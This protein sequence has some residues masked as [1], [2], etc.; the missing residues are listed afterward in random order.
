MIRVNT[1]EAK[2]RLSALLAKVERDHE[3]VIIC[4]DGKPVARLEAI[5]V[6]AIDPLRMNP[7]LG[8]VV[9]HENPCA[10]LDEQ[11]WPKEAP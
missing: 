2:M 4:R 7:R 8:P 11:D 10:G 5:E 3:A 9:F 1:H 6:K